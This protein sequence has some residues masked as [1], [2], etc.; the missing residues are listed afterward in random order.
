MVDQR[1]SEKS[2]VVFSVVQTLS[3]FNDNPCRHRRLDVLRMGDGSVYIET[4]KGFVRVSS[5]EAI[6]ATL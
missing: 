2:I 1:N 5:S 6:K 3:A 4:G